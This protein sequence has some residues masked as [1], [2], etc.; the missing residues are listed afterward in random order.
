MTKK[1]IQMDKSAFLIF[2]QARI[3]SEGDDTIRTELQNVENQIESHN[4]SVSN[5]SITSH[6]IRNGTYATFEISSPVT[7]APSIA[8]SDDELLGGETKSEG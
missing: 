4:F 6:I 5:L 7:P 2:L 3:F 1:F 8:G